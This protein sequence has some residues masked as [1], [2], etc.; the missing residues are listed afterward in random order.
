MNKIKIPLP[1]TLVRETDGPV[2]VKQIQSY[3][4]RAW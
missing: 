4:E 1:V 3:E 2:N